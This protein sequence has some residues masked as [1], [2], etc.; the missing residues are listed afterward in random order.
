L[1]GGNDPLRRVRKKRSPGG[2]RAD[3]GFE[4]EGEDAQVHFEDTVKGSVWGGLGG[5][6]GT[7]KRCE[8]TEKKKN[9]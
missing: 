7:A 4:G 9:I 1:G 3:G 8:V 5:V 2:K 6:R